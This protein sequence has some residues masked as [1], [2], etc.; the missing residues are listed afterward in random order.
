MVEGYMAYHNMK[1]ISEYLHKLASKRNLCHTCDRDSNKNFEGEY[2]IG[3]GR[4]RKLKVN[5]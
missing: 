5:Y 1:Y 3:K 4:S 2:L